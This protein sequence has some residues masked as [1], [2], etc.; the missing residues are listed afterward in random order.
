MPTIE[1][2]LKSTEVA[3]TPE[4]WDI[5]KDCTL[6][7]REHKWQWLFDIAAGLPSETEAICVH[8]GKRT[9]LTRKDQV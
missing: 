5:N 9:D 7:K 2:K 3:M 4:E 1:G 8:C 6:K